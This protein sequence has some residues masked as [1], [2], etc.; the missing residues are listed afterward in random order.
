[1]LLARSWQSALYNPGGFRQE[2]FR[3]RLPR[4]LGVVTLVV[5]A[6]ALVK[7]GLDQGMFRDLVV[8]LV[9]LY[10]FQ[11]VAC[12][13]RWIADRGMSSGWLVGMYVLLLIMPQLVLFMACVGMADS[14]LGGQKLLR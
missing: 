14:W 7:T 8:V 2:F 11:G 13:H 4:W 12:A 6:L 10:L 5:T 3:L 1:M 9:F